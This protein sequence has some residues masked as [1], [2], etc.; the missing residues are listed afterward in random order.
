[1]FEQPSENQPT[2]NPE[3]HFEPPVAPTPP[4]TITPTP[5]RKKRNSFIFILLLLIVV[6]LAAVATYAVMTFVIGSSKKTDDV[7]NQTTTVTPTVSQS[8]EL[9]SV[10]A[11]VKTMLPSTKAFIATEGA[12]LP[13]RKVGDPYNFYAIGTKNDAW[14]IRTDAVATASVA[15]VAKSLYQYFVTDQKATVDTLIGDTPLVTMGIDTETVNSYRINA[16]DYT[17][18]LFRSDVLASKAPFASIGSEIDITC[19]TQEEFVK[20]A[21][22]QLPFYTAISSDKTYTADVTVLGAPVIKDAK[23]TNYK[24]AQVGI[25]SQLALVGGAAGLFYQTPDGVWHFFVGTQSELN[26]SQYSTTDLKKAYL[27]EQCYDEAKKA[28]STVTLN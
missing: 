21:K 13:Y 6:A 4:L 26:C 23:T 3:P 1:M 22:T 5:V 18:S 25:G 12:T 14:R 2:P 27:G 11:K 17:C 20:N 7:A 19:S 24:T 15:G 16:A 8:D 28:D 9:V 10:I